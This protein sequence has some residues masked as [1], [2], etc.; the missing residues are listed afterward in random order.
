MESLPQSTLPITRHARYAEGAGGCAGYSAP[1][2]DR[3]EPSVSSREG[4]RD[5]RKFEIRSVMRILRGQLSE[6]SPEARLWLA[7][8]E[9]AVRDAYSSGAKSSETRDDARLWLRSDHFTAVATAIGLN[10]EWALQKIA[11]IAGDDEE[12]EAASL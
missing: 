6:P 10:P 4:Y 12:R 1:P 2:V 3:T 8:I 7:V 11:Q 9:F 5:Q